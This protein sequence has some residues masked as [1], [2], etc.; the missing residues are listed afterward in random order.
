MQAALSQQTQGFYRN[1]IA[2]HDIIL[3]I[4]VS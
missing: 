4:L 2:G 3:L 1:G